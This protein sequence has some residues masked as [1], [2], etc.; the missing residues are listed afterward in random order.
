[1]CPFTEAIPMKKHIINAILLSTL[2]AGSSCKDALVEKP[3]GFIQSNQLGD[4]P[5]L[6]ARLLVNGALSTL[7]EDFLYGQYPRAL[8][9][10]ADH[11][12]GP[13]WAMGTIGSGNFQS[14]AGIVD[15]MWGGSY[16]LI[17]RSNQ[18]IAQIEAFTMDKK[19]N[20]NALDEKTKKNALG[21]LYFLKAWGYFQLVRAYG[22][23]PIFKES[24]TKGAAIQQPRASVQEVYAYIIENLKMAEQ[25]LLGV[26]DAGYETGTISKGAASSLL[27][28]VYLTM[29]S[30]ALSGAQ[31]TVLGGPAT[32]ISDGASVQVAKPVA[33]THTKTVVAGLEG[34]DAMQYF[35]LAR[36]KANEVMKSGDYRLFAA[37]REVWDVANRN[38]GEH[39][40]SLQSLSRDASLGNPIMTY[41]IGRQTT[42]NGIDGRFFGCRAHW[43]A[44]FESTDLRVSEGV[45]A[46][47]NAAYLRKFEAVT[48]R[49]AS[50]SDFHFPFLRYADVLLLFAEAE[51]ELN[52][53]PTTDAFQAVNAIRGRNNASEVKDLNRQ[54]F[55]SFV[56]EERARE[57]ALEGNRRWD[58]LR[59]G[60]YRQVM[61]AVDTDE[62]NVV[63][64]RQD[65]HLLYPIPVDEINA[66]TLIKGNNPGW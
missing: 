66:N 48:D 38:K 9:L 14:D 46:G 36:D 58:L 49:T 17:N 6:N 54:Q 34:L 10:D 13:A 51:N 5:Q 45:F 15:R 41:Y 52:N 1:M 8:D 43:T 60:I 26:K 59:W 19:L 40:W 64:R 4:N 61:S 23:V 62:N 63:K 39:I 32:K 42:N 56:L 29:A 55:R 27:A 35:Q 50:N 28:K 21:K 31:V 25:S 57:L 47:Y 24:I 12:T 65:K 11:I 16:L 3:K 30:G 33:L 18:A 22:G 44:L 53:G 20:A 7:N 2:L 37:Y